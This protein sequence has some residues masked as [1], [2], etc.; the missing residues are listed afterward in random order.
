MAR[1]LTLALVGAVVTGL[2]VGCSRSAGRQGG[3]AARA[4]SPNLNEEQ[5]YEQRF[6]TTEYNYEPFLAEYYRDGA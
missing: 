1:L 3:D 2:H 5:Y 4:D 6:S